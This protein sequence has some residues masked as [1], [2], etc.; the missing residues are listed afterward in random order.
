MSRLDAHPAQSKAELVA[1]MR[2]LPWQRWDGAMIRRFLEMVEERQRQFPATDASFVLRKSFGLPKWIH[3]D[4]E[5]EQRIS[6]PDA[7]AAAQFVALANLRL[8]CEGLQR[9]L[10][11]LLNHDLRVRDTHAGLAHEDRVEIQ[12][13]DPRALDD[14]LGDVGDQPRERGDVRL[15]PAAHAEQEL[16][17]L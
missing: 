2:L 8:Q 13:A 15:R 10:N 7:D 14:E 4:W 5:R 9:R 6:S 1:T 3:E 16:P 11:A 17:C 12:L